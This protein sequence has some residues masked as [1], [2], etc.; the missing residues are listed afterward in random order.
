MLFGDETGITDNQ[1]QLIKDHFLRMFVSRR[2]GYPYLD[3]HVREVEKWAI[4]I[5]PKVEMVRM[6]IIQAS[7]WL[8]DIGQLFGDPDE[9]HAVKSAVEASRFLAG[10]N[11]DEKSREQTVLSVRSHRCKDILPSTLEAKI[12]AAADSASHLTDINYIVHLSDY[13]PQFVMAKLE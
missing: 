6:D 5:I 7:V 11:I 2:Q 9:D 10:L 1:L 13:N 12:L 4:R 3:R 8:H